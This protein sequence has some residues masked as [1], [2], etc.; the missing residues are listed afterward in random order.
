MNPQSIEGV[1]QEVI[2]DFRRE[3]GEN[4]GVHK[5]LSGGDYYVERYT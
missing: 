1:P 4:W 2:D 5:M 3:Y